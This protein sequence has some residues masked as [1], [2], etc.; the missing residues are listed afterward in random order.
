MVTFVELGYHQINTDQSFRFKSSYVLSTLLTNFFVLELVRAYVLL[1]KK[2]QLKEIESENFNYE[3]R[4]LHE[5]WTHELKESEREKGNTYMLRDR[6]RWTG[7]QLMVAGLQKL[8][9]F[10]ITLITFLDVIYVGLITRENF[11]KRTFKNVAVK[12]KIIVQESSILVFLIVLTI[13][14]CVQGQKFKTSQV[15]SGLEILV[16]V[17]V[18]LTIGTEVICSVWNIVIQVLAFLR[19]RKELKF[20][21]KTEEIT[22]VEKETRCTAEE[23]IVQKQLSFQKAP[24]FDKRIQLKAAEKAT[25]SPGFTN[26]HGPKMEKTST[27]LSPAIGDVSE[28]PRQEME[29]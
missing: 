3:Q 14:S 17:S 18:F 21:K 28:I 8:P 20:N 24:L 19:K 12:L 15:Y 6:L 29:I 25:H 7:F 27:V 2:K 10:Q 13:F 9:V 23:G 4:L 11:Q 26:R 1:K 22:K 16:I 5:A